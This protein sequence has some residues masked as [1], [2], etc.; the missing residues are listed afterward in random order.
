MR[1][2]TVTRMKDVERLP[3]ECLDP[4]FLAVYLEGELTSAERA[5][6]ETHLCDCRPCRSVVAAAI[7]SE[8]SVALPSHTDE[9]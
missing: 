7:R 1:P 3:G 9:S 2:R 8:D 5:L 6:V 4:E